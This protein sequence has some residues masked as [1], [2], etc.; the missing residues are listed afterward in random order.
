MKSVKKQARELFER[1]F[2]KEKLKKMEYL[3]KQ[4]REN[5]EK[6]YSNKDSSQPNIPEHHKHRR[7]RQKSMGTAA[8]DDIIDNFLL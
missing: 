7:R 6:S 2:L 4:Q 1:I 3:K 5:K 8:N